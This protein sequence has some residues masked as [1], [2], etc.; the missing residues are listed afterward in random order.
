MEP[1][2]LARFP[3]LPEAS[4]YVAEEGPSLEELLTD[5]FWVRARARGRDRVL[6]ALEEAELPLTVPTSAAEAMVDLLAYGVG[7]MIVS[8]TKDPYV[9]RRHALAEAV[10]VKQLLDREEDPEVVLLA[11]DLLGLAAEAVD[12]PDGNHYRM[13]FTAYIQRASALKDI[14]WKLVNQA[15]DRGMVTLPQAKYTRLIQEALRRRIEKELPLQLPDEVASA[16]KEEVGAVEAAA[17]VKKEKFEAQAF[18]EVNLDCMP[19]CM[20]A[21]LG[22]LQA[23]EN[24]PHSARFAITSFLHTIGLNSEEIIKLFSAAPDF[25]EDMTRYQVEHITGK[26][27]ANE[28]TPPGCGTMVTYGICYN[29][30]Q[31]CKA[32]DPKDGHPY[33]THP[34][35]YYRWALK[36]AGR[37]NPKPAEP[38]APAAPPPVASSENP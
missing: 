5:R 22:M 8:A 15:L 20:K 24:A 38:A 34:L 19:P 32:R 14:E 16:L 25:K 3:F 37:A 6:Q 11:G 4:G 18:G 28:Y 17:K 9:V 23:G 27:S 1:T 26:S 29:P 7:R 13:H 12:R 30:D 21:I 31:W 35:S 10:R 36:R 33:V 2:V